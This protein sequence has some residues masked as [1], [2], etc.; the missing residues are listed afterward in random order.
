MCSHTIATAESD[1]LLLAFLENYLKYAKTL[2][3]NRSVTPNYTQLSMVDLPRR[4]AGRKGGKAPKKPISR[5]KV[6]PSE[7]QPRSAEDL[8][9]S[10]TAPTIVNSSTAPGSSH[11][12]TESFSKLSLSLTVITTSSGNWSWNWGGPSFHVMPSPYTSYFSPS[13]PPSY[14]SPS[15]PAYY[16]PPMPYHSPLMSLIIIHTHV[17]LQLAQGLY[18]LAASS[19]ILLQQFLSHF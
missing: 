11:D 17:D 13:L 12:S 18:P 4:T 3:G 19:K 8:D 5:R 6:T 1:G 2:K 9:I 14:P 15:Y 10:A 7:R 16:P